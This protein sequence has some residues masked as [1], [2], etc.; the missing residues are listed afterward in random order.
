MI[1]AFGSDDIEE[2]IDNLDDDD[3]DYFYNLLVNGHLGDIMEA[4]EFDA[5]YGDYGEDKDQDRYYRSY[6]DNEVEEEEEMMSGD[7][8]AFCTKLSAEICDETAECCQIADADALKDDS[9]LEVECRKEKG[10]FSRHKHCLTKCYTED[11]KCS[12]HKDCCSGICENRKK[13]FFKG[14]KLITC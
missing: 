14:S 2:W 13:T 10:W 9:T 3:V 6:I 8:D 11:E 5:G 1:N 4:F 12:D 7:E